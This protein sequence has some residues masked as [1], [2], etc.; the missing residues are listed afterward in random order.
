MIG[1]IKLGALSPNDLMLVAMKLN[2]VIEK[3]DKAETGQSE[4]ALL[5]AIPQQKQ[6]NKE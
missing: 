2:D 5:D 1:K 4:F 3:L 6:R